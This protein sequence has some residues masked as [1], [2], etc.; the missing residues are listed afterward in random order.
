MKETR[1]EEMTSEKE[2][3]RKKHEKLELR[4]KQMENDKNQLIK[5]R[6]WSSTSELQAA[7]CCCIEGRGG[8]YGKVLDV[9]TYQVCVE[10][11]QSVGCVKARS[12]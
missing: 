9:Q 5:V 10:T 7:S 11:K 12:I 4:F 8:V 3:L 2:Q 1:L 6:S